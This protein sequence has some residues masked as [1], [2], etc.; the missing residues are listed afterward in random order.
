MNGM[1]PVKAETHTRDEL[2]EIC[3]G[4]NDAVS[5]LIASPDKNGPVVIFING[6]ARAGKSLIWDELVTKLLGETAQQEFSGNNRSVERWSGVDQQT[7][8]PLNIFAC[9]LKGIM[10][11]TK[12]AEFVQSFNEIADDPSRKQELR[13]LGDV[14][15]LNNADYPGNKNEFQT[16][17]YV[18]DFQIDLNWGQ[19]LSLASWDRIVEIQQHPQIPFAGD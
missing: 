3:K 6:A 9:N 15:I 4:F 12:L 8:A 14:I 2:V 7:N 16:L 13:E 11:K 5:N 1:P 17:L 18:P 10:N 19:D